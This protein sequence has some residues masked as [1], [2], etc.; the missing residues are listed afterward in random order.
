MS[1]K[2]DLSALATIV[3]PVTVETS[4]LELRAEYFASSI[5]LEALRGRYPSSQILSA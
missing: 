2:P 5:D 1:E 3:T 4:R